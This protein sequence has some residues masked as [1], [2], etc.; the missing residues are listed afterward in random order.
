LVGIKIENQLI[1]SNRLGIKVKKKKKKKMTCE[2]HAP[3]CGGWQWAFNSEWGIIQ[4]SIAV[5][6]DALG[7]VSASTSWK[8]GMCWWIFH[9][10]TQKMCFSSFF[11]FFFFLVSF[12]PLDSATCFFFFIIIIIIW[13]FYNLQVNLICN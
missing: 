10:V 13:L 11:F 3:A 9:D 2:E 4:P 6:F 12:L 7:T 1:N 8:G 5:F